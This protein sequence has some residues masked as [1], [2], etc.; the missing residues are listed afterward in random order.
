MSARFGSDFDAMFGGQG[1]ESIVLL[2]VNSLRPFRDH[3][4]KVL[5]DAAMDALVESIRTYGVEQPIVVRPHPDGR[6]YE[7]LAGHRREHATKLAG[8]EHIPGKVKVVDDDEAEMIML[9]TNLHRPELLPSE[10]AVSYKKWRD[11]KEKKVGRPKVGEESEGIRWDEELAKEIGE[12]RASIQRYIR[13]TYLCLDLLNLVDAK[14]IKLGPAEQLSYL[15]DVAQAVM[16]AYLEA[17]GKA[18]S[19][20]QARNIRELAGAGQL[21]ATALKAVYSSQFETNKTFEQRATIDTQKL[22]SYFPAE[23]T[24]AQKEE[25]LISLLEKWVKDGKEIA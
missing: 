17:G 25:L 24:N 13:L 7:I 6:G 1:G 16:V 22:E 14:K 4:Y 21:T 20:V 10:K 8:L 9:I 5:D 3:T 18:P 23:Y 11:N 15:D 12:S 19:L 2:D